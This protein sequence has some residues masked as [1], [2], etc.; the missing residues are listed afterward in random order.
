[1]QAAPAQ[2]GRG[3]HLSE[4]GASGTCRQHSLGIGDRQSV[5]ADLALMHRQTAL[6]QGSGGPG[7]ARTRTGGCADGHRCSTANQYA[8]TLWPCCGRT[9]PD[10]GGSDAK[11]PERFTETGQAGFPTFY[12]K[13][14]ANAT[15]NVAIDGLTLVEVTARDHLQEIS[16]CQRRRR[17]VKEHCCLQD[18]KAM[19]LG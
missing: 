4:S 10:A 13:V 12:M 1:M 18:R 2:A 19:R 6:G 17:T 16:R 14:S 3:K 8:Q 7:G 11:S 5:E 9:G 15:R